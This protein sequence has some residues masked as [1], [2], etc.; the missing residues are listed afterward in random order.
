MFWFRPPNSV[1]PGAEGDETWR[2]TAGQNGSFVIRR[3]F[4]ASTANETVVCETAAGEPC[5]DWL[6]QRLLQPPSG[7][8]LAWLA[9][10]LLLQ[11]PYPIVPE[12]AGS[13]RLVHCFGP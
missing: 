10:K 12:D 3:R 4:S 11:Q 13:H 7:N 1:L 9:G 6:R 8:M 5:P 2:A